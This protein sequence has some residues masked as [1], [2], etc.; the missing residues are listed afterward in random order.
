MPQQPFSAGGRHF[1]SGERFVLLGSAWGHCEVRGRLSVTRRFDLM[2][3]PARGTTKTKALLRTEKIL[4]GEHVYGVGSIRGEMAPRRF[5]GTP[6]GRAT[7]AG[8]LLVRKPL[9]SW[10]VGRARGAADL[11]V[12]KELVSHSAARGR[13]VAALRTE[14]VLGGPVIAGR[15]VTEA[16]LLVRKVFATS[17]RGNAQAVAELLTLKQLTG[18]FRGSSAA[19]AALRAEKLLGATPKGSVS[20]LAALRTAKV[21]SGPTINGVGSASGRLALLKDLV[22]AASGRTIAIA[23]MEPL[24]TYRRTEDDL[25]ARQTEAGDVRQTERDVN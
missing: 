4:L 10:T 6:A 1:F 20:F 3:G 19:T 8:T 16:Q 13:A 22:G 24:V 9:T 7:V 18:A 25:D 17:A 11:V 2:Q 14:K 15:G 12:R 5:E 23:Q 21:L